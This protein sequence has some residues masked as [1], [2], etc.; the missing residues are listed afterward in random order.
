MSIS[1]VYA[2]KCTEK[3]PR[4]SRTYKLKFKDFYGPTLFIRI[5]KALNSKKKF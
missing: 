4:L 2:A 5:F 1:L 3:N